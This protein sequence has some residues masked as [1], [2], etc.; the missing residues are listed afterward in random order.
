MG[1]YFDGETSPFKTA[2]DRK[3][4]IGQNIRYVRE[5]DIDRSGRGFF[6]PRF[7]FVEGAKGRNIFLSNGSVLSAG[8]LVEVQ[9]VPAAPDSAKGGADV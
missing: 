2:A 6:F 4:L 5:C 8:D 3:K 9:I 1:A 7:D